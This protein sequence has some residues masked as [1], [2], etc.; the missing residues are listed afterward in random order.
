MSSWRQTR[1]LHLWA[2]MVTALLGLILPVHRSFTQ[3][4]REDVSRPTLPFPWTVQV[5]PRS[6]LDVRAGN[7][8]SYGFTL[9]V[10]LG[11]HE[12]KYGEFTHL[13][14]AL[15]GDLQYDRLGR[16]RSGRSTGAVSTRF[17]AAGV[18]L[19]YFD[20]WPRVGMLHGRDRSALEA[21]A[22]FDLS[23]AGPLARKHRLQGE[24]SVKLSRTLA[25]GHYRPNLFVL[26]R[27]KGIAEPV[28]LAA[29]ADNWNEQQNK[30]LPLVKVGD[31]ASPRLPWSILSQVRYRGQV[32]L[33]SDED[34]RS[35]SLVPRS[36]FYSMFIIKPGRYKISPDFPTIFN[37]RNMPLIAGGDV[38]IPRALHNYIRWDRGKVSL[39]VRGPAGVEDKG[40]RKFSDT[41]QSRLQGGGFDV[42]MTRTGRYTLDLNGHIGELYGR[43]FTGGG[44]YTVHVALP[45]SFSTS[46]KPGT[47]FLVGGVYPPK[48]NVNP[49]FP[50]DVEVKV[51]FYPGGQRDRKRTWVAS[52]RANRFGHFVPRDKLPMA[53]D[54]PG[55][56][57]SRV[58]ARY[59]DRTGRLWMAE[60]SST[61]V[62]APRQRRTVRI[63]GTRSFPYGLRVGEAYNGGVK[64]FRHR[65]DMSTSFLP[66]SPTMLPDPYVP[67]APT[68]TLFISS[69]GYNESLVE[70][71]LSVAI[72]DPGLRRRLQKAH[73]V[74]SFLVPPMYQP[75]RGKWR[76]LRDVVQLSTDSG[77]WFPAD[78]AHADE[79]PVL[80]VSG[81]GLHAF[82]RPEHNTVEAYT[83]MGIFRPGV[84]VMTSVHQR[85]ALGLYWLTSPN[86]LGHHLNNGPNGDLP[87]DLYRVQAGVMLKD[88]VTGKTHYDAYS[89][90]IA[91]TSP[92]VA[93]TAILPPG[94]RPLV[95]VGERQHH[96]FL[97]T[98]T[99]DTQEVGETLHLGGMVFPAVRAHVTWTVTTPGG[100]TEVSRGQADR[101]GVVR[102][103]IA[104]PV[105]A[106]GAYRIKVRVR[107][108]ELTG[109]VVGT[110]DGTY[111]VFAVAR[112][113][114]ELLS[115]NLGG[116]TRVAPR[117]G[118]RVPLTWPAGLRDVK[119]RWGVLMPGQVLDQGTVRP[120]TNSH[121]Y[122]LEPLHIA[123]Q[124][125]NFDVRNFKTGA[126]SLADIV[127][128]QF[129]LEGDDA[130]GQRVFDS[131]R[132]VMRGDRLYNYRALLRRGKGKKTPGGGHGARPHGQ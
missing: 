20:G 66:T 127:V 121:G 84:P 43:R 1:G 11:A 92:G 46:C 120:A 7:T 30:P 49:P 112:G 6:A 10:D 56:Y 73:R 61:G 80:S 96:L 33:L 119:L 118:I 16:Y 85:D 77:G 44:T 99:H 122:P 98:D 18:P 14:V 65:Q 55:E 57:R 93:G 19:E 41:S 4:E 129:F 35:V 108:G 15:S 103:H 28:H 110:A 25:P 101:L 78:A 62:I 54:E 75:S 114:P 51:D 107:H 31:A 88:R 116:V 109:D 117:A 71:H 8:L 123:S 40:S 53:F 87:E 86:D 50:A 69:G 38:V 59:T 23:R 26:V 83:I 89:A 24:L 74:P 72:D 29:F 79:L 94:E 34:R 132:L 17:T 39:R 115:T 81:K 12:A 60:Q 130:A 76:Y 64:R 48:V 90:A 126:W 67:Y 5:T 68:D 102:G 95:T 131:L 13:I 63:H 128:L 104:L 70:P 9:D 97:A 113:N 2:A 100:R 27:V 36:G 111:F 3:H 22:S 124:F 32:G 105:D 42:D 45:L 82:A 58:V 47:S 21:V 52:G 125:P 37:Q 106:P 91:V